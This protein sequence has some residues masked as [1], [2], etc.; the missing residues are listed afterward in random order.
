MA[1]EGTEVARV[2]RA[3]AAMVKEEAEVVGVMRVDGVCTRHRDW[4]GRTR[5]IRKHNRHHY[6]E[7][8]TKT[9]VFRLLPDYTGYLGKYSIAE[10]DLE[11]QL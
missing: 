11:Q 10:V 2:A 5:W 3:A 7:C 1:E 4:K 6:N 8:S 9:T